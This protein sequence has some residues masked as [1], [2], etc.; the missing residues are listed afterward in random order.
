MEGRPVSKELVVDPRLFELSS[1]FASLALIGWAIASFLSGSALSTGSAVRE[2]LAAQLRVVRSE[3]SM[4]RSELTDATIVLAV[5]VSL[6]GMLVQGSLLMGVLAVLLWISRPSM[7][8]A[9]REERPLW[10]I[11]GTLSSDLVIGVLVPIVLAQLLIGG[12]ALAASLVLVMISLSWPP[13]GA[14]SG[15]S[16]SWRPAWQA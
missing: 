6:I 11:A 13:G 12:Y 9:M 7:A 3:S 16:G 1:A 2:A 4:T 8:R 14:A 15:G 5:G 10:A